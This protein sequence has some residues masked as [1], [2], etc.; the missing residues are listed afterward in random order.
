M[1]QLCC[2]QLIFPSG[3]LWNVTFTH[4]YEAGGGLRRDAAHTLK[5]HCLERGHQLFIHVSLTLHH[6]LKPAEPLRQ[7]DHNVRPD[8]DKTPR[9]EPERPR[10]HQGTD[11]L[12]HTSPS[13]V[14]SSRLLQPS[15]FMSSV[16]GNKV[17][18]KLLLLCKRRIACGASTAADL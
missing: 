10:T 2:S 18:H 4:G 13:A 9:T 17:I 14:S 12:A 1:N 16:R 8:R 11:A 5:H 7:F 6:P 3:S 15:R